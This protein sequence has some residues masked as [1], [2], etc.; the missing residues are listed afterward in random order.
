MNFIKDQHT[1]NY[2]PPTVNTLP[3]PLYVLNQNIF[4]C[5]LGSPNNKFSTITAGQLKAGF[6]LCYLTAVLWKLSNV[7]LE[8]I[9]ILYVIDIMLEVFSQMH[10]ASIILKT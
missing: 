4:V 8:D 9:P 7:A 2:L 5:L 10:F 3:P 1:L 6:L